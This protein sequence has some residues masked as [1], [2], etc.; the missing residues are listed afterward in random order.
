MIAAVGK[1][2]GA[3]A[4]A[5]GAHYARLGVPVEGIVVVPGDEDGEEAP[6][7]HLPEAAGPPA[8]RPGTAGGLV[9]LAG[10]HPVPDARS[11]AAGEALLAAC[12][13]LGEAD[14][15]LVLIS[16]GASALATVPDGVPLADLDELTR[17]L[18]ASGA[19][20]GEINTVR[21]KL[22]RIKG[23]GLARAAAPARVLGLVV[24]DV[25]GDDPA[26][27][28]SGPTVPDPDGPEAALAVLRRH[29]ITQ[30]A[31]TRRLEELAAMPPEPWPGNAETKI[32]AGAGAALAAAGGSLAA[33]GYASHLL[34]GFIEGDSRAAA[35]FHAAVVR[36]ILA[37][38]EPFRRPCAIISGGETTVTI[39]PGVRPGS[40]GRNSD[41]VL[42]LAC[43]LWGVPRVHAL[44]ADSDGLDGSAPAA[45]GFLGPR[46]F[47]QAR[48][49]EARAALA[50]FDS[51]GFLARHG[52]A[53]LTGATGTN[54]NDVRMILLD[55]PR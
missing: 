23:G 13:G 54:V 55:A 12:R 53:F 1:G 4:A 35:R 18:L 51:H 11:V 27:I 24:S 49:D 22:C 42:A 7:P 5:A 44:A 45:G 8:S 48:E 25:V 19:G 10:S 16:G 34:T 21:R 41:F 38:D 9:T 29:G 33:A 43:E 6:R 36:Q 52:H 37:S 31:V 50:A 28:A 3:M 40:G 14:L 46:L 47:G 39:P 15:V 17:A 2:A 20:I 32:I 26:A 30:E